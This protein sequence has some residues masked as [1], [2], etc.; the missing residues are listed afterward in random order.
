MDTSFTIKVTELDDNFLKTIQ[1]AFKN[2]R[3]VT[4]NIS[5]SVD[6]DLNKFETKEEYIARI[7]KAKNNL[8]AG[9]GI[10]YPEAELNELFLNTV[11]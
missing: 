1:T 11:L 4:I 9:K 2:E 3:K 7:L 5:S 6:F 10:A 8:E